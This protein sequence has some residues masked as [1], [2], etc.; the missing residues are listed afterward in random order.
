MEPGPLWIRSQE[1]WP[2]DHRSGQFIKMVQSL[3]Q[4]RFQHNI[5]LRTVPYIAECIWYNT[6]RIGK[7]KQPEL[8]CLNRWYTGIWSNL[9]SHCLLPVTNCAPRVGNRWKPQSDSLIRLMNRLGVCIMRPFS[10]TVNTIVTSRGDN[11][12][13]SPIPEITCDKPIWWIADPS[14]LYSSPQGFVQL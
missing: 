12:G 1:L 14:H 5:Y 11:G 2:L 13:S 9:S 6:H 3:L 10:L 7:R 8:S 4:T